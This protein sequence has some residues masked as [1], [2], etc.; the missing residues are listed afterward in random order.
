MSFLFP[1]DKGPSA[2]EV[3]AKQREEADRRRQGLIGAAREQQN[4]GINQLIGARTN[5]NPSQ[6]LPGKTS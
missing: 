2:E 3:L 5:V 4:K 1:S 6:D